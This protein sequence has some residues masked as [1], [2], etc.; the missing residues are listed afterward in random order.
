MIA[1]IALRREEVRALC[2]RFGVRRLAL[3]GSAARDDFDPERSD[4]DFLYEFEAKP[5]GGY[6]DGFLRAFEELVGEFSYSGRPGRPWSLRSLSAI[7]I[8]A[9]ALDETRGGGSMP[10]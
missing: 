4:L 7:A 5:P 8:S 1:E 10:A 6:A 9:R 3:F 2:R